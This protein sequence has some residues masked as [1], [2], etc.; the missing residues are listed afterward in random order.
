MPAPSLTRRDV[1]VDRCRGLVLLLHGGQQTSIEAVERRN[2]SWARMAA[3]QGALA[4]VAHRS[5]V[6]VWLLRYGQ[7][8]WNAAPGREAAPV[9]DTRWAQ[10]QVRAAYGDV[11]VV[12]LGHSMGGRTAVAAADDAAVTGVVGLAPWWPE[13]ESVRAVAGKPLAAIHGTADRWT[14]AQW[15]RD[16]A[17]RARAAG[18]PVT[19]ETLTGAGHFMLRR[20]ATW[21]RFVRRCS[22]G[23]LRVGPYEEA[24]RERLS[25]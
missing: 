23:M 5:Q 22:L 15:S 7:R 10:E 19:Y 17:E 1:A 13:H 18:S 2:L 24:L 16:F 11:P 12:L 6:A 20:F 25:R 14:S 4:P 21:D 8:G 3:I 9:Q